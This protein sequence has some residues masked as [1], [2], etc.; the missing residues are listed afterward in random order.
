[1]TGH[2]HRKDLIVGLGKVLG[3]DGHVRCH[4]AIAMEDE[5]DTLSLIVRW[6]PPEILQ[7]DLFAKLAPRQ[8]QRVDF[9]PH[10]T[11]PFKVVKWH[12]IADVS[13]CLG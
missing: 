6:G 9:G 7:L 3:N 1:M 4:R 13:L 8:V 11:T 2:V 12:H 10:E 5:N